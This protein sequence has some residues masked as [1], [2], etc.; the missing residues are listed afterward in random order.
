MKMGRR[1]KVEVALVVDMID[2][3]ARKERDEGGNEALRELWWMIRIQST[4]TLSALVAF[5]KPPEN[6]VRGC[7]FPRHHFECTDSRQPPCSSFSHLSPVSDFMESKERL[8]GSPNY[9]NSTWTKTEGI[10][11]ASHTARGGRKQQATLTL[12]FTLHIRPLYQG[13]AKPQTSLHDQGRN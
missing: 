13:A 2:Q 11:F 6:G 12:L 5:V 7:P 9:L 4:N 10:L 8:A 1:G 3:N